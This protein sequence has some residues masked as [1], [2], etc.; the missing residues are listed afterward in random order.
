MQTY[1]KTCRINHCT[2]KLYV[3]NTDIQNS[4]SNL[5]LRG[6][7][8]IILKSVYSAT[9]RTPR[10]YER[11]PKPLESVIGI[12]NLLLVIKARKAKP[13]PPVP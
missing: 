2:L 9:G 11:V 10:P 3:Y 6:C 12:L 13:G 7:N 5:R 1:N 8:Y 4:P